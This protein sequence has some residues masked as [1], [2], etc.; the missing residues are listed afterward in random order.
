MISYIILLLIIFSVFYF[1]KLFIKKKI[2]LSHSGDNHQKF[3]EKNSIPLLGGIYLIILLTF[4]LFKIE[5]YFPILILFLIFFL[6]IFTDLKILKSPK[7]RLLIQTVI[8]ILLVYCSKLQIIDTRV[9]YLDLIIEQKVINFCF[10][11]F[12][13]LILIN[14]SNFIDGLNGVAIGYFIIITIFLYKL[15]FFLFYKVETEVFIIYLIYIII[16]F[17]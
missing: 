10:V 14:G 4:I 5:N 2:L 9:E 3:V 16:H 6:G 12:C 7:K 1:N 17:L 8:I 11:I 13:L 15:D